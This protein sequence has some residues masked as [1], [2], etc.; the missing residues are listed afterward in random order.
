M[1][2]FV[3][4]LSDRAVAILAVLVPIAFVV[5]V[6]VPDILPIID[7]AFLASWSLLLWKESF[8]RGKD[9][10]ERLGVPEM[11]EPPAETDPL[12]DRPG[13]AR[14]TLRGVTARVYPLTEQR[15]TPLPNPDGEGYDEELLN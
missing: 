12:F 6:I 1:E 14:V 10:M 5:D 3:R 7:E 2:L 4:N 9:R 8:R 13:C 15:S 11:T